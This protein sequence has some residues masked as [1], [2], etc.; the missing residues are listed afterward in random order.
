MMWQ[1]ISA[2]PWAVAQIAET[3]ALIREQKALLERLQGVEV[4]AAEHGGAAPSV[5]LRVVT[6]GRVTPH[7]VPVLA[8]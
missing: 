1:A 6:H 8:T 2:G 7:S 5:T 4:A 3:D